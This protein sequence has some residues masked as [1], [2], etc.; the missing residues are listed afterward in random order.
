[1]PAQRAAQLEADPEHSA[2]W[3]ERRDLL[4]A[5]DRVVGRLGGAEIPFGDQA[6]GQS[7]RRHHEAHAAWRGC[8]CRLGVGLGLAQ[9][10]PRAV[11]VRAVHPGG[12]EGLLRALTASDFR[13]LLG[14]A[15]GGVEVIGPAQRQQQAVRAAVADTSGEQLVGVVGSSLCE[16]ADL[17]RVERAVWREQAALND[18]LDQAAE[19]DRL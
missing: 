12:R 9:A 11:E 7:D 16:R 1:V 2:V 15:F 13:P 4:S 5:P 3:R 6:V 17:G 10:P 14:H 18:G 19:R 8:G